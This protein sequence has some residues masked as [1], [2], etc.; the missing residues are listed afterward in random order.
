MRNN[1]YLTPLENEAN[2]VLAQI[3]KLEYKAEASSAGMAMDCGGFAGFELNHDTTI[4]PEIMVL[5]DGGGEVRFGLEED[6][7]DPATYF[8]KVKKFD[9]FTLPKMPGFVFSMKNG[10]LDLNTSQKIEQA[11]L[12][13]SQIETSKAHYLGKA[14]VTLP[15]EYD[16]TGGGKRLTLDE[17]AFAIEKDGG[18][19]QFFK[20]K[21]R[22]VGG[23]KNRHLELRCGR[24]FTQREGAVWHRPFRQ[25]ESARAG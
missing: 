9:D 24:A 11:K 15:A 20:E 8:G 2:Q 12:P 1:S 6:G 4:D 17:G 25:A 3:F 19:G 5:A 13:A 18:N 16:F 10:E 14:E 23:G 7:A 22:L 21:P